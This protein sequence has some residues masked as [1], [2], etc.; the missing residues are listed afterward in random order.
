M[1]NISGQKMFAV[2]PSSKTYSFNTT[3]FKNGIYIV[4]VVSN[5]K[6]ETYKVLLRD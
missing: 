3:S 1:Y 6:F 4:R 2:R 5:N